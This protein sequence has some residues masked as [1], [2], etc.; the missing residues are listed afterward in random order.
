MLIKLIGAC[1]DGID[2][3]IE[4]QQEKGSSWNFKEVKKLEI[5]IVKN[6]PIN[7]S[8][9]IHLPDWIKNK[10]AIVNIKNKDEKCFFGVY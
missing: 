5:H 2:G 8:S 6:N 7:G 9:Y 4:S 1:I 10:K 3:S